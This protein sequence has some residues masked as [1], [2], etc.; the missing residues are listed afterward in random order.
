MAEK[1][2]RFVM[3]AISFFLWCSSSQT[4]PAL[5][6]RVT[7]SLDSLRSLHRGNAVWYA[8]GVLPSGWC[9]NAM[10]MRNHALMTE[11]ASRRLVMVDQMRPPA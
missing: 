9:G 11:R 1:P 5:R 4:R 3:S 8:G 7:V 2:D 10:N 6:L